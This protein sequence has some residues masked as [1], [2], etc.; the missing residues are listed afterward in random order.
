VSADSDK[1]I[2][3]VTERT[4]HALNLAGLEPETIYLIF[5]TAVRISLSVHQSDGHRGSAGKSLGNE[6]RRD[7]NV[8][9]TMYCNVV[10]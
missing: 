3:L 4:R 8:F 7:F 6:E 5:R 2:P 1:G 9:C 10:I